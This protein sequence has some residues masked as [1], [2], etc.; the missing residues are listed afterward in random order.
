MAG[1]N[2]VSPKSQLIR[3]LRVLLPLQSQQCISTKAKRKMMGSQLLQPSWPLYSTVNLDHAG[4]HSF[5]MDI[6]IDEPHDFSSS[7]ATEESSGIS[8]DSY[9]AAMTS[10]DSLV[11]FPIFDDEK[12]G[13]DTMAHIMDGLEPIS[14]SGA[15]EE[16]CQWLEESD[17]GEDYISSQLTPEADAWRACPPMEQSKPGS[18]STMNA[19]PSGSMSLTFPP[20]NNMGTD[21]QLGL[22]HLLTAHGEAVGNGHQELAEVIVR[23]ITER[24]DPLGEALERLAFNLFQSAENQ[25]CYLGQQSTKNFE[26][27][28]KAFYQWFPYGRFAHFTANSAILEAMPSDAE[29]IHIVDFDMGEGIQWPPL[30]DSISRKGKSLRLTSIISGDSCWVFEETRQRLYDH[31][32][33][34]G[35]RL[36]V[37]EMALEDLVA[38]MK[39]TKKK[40]GAREWLAFNLMVALPHMGRRADRRRVVEFLTLAKD[41]LVYSAG[42][43]GIITIGDGEGGGNLQNCPEYSSFFNSHFTHYQALFESME[44]N[45]PVYLA[46]ARI[47]MESLFLAPYVSSHS[48][49]Q[50]WQDARGSQP[51]CGLDGRRMSRDCLIEAKEIVNE[52]KASYKVNFQKENENEIVLEWRGIPLVRVSS[53]I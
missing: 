25:G 45:F 10:P 37:E 12:R 21:T 42:D 39:R 7:F 41:L 32:R 19:T 2:P 9:F 36:N 17:N 13:G 35:L 27:A 3:E 38:E 48:W 53:W 29:T 46:E 44:C 47:A 6:C 28:F 22:H 34:L 26:A 30:M 33:S 18:A 5:P 8:F 50:H 51:L 1:G 4:L 23:R 11:E 24:I 52:Q 43:K 20:V 49:F 31:A 16:D 15:I 40:G 14:S